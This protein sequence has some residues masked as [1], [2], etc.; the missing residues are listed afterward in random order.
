M[1]IEGANIAITGKAEDYLIERG[2]LVIPDFVA[3][4]GGLIGSYTEFIRKTHKET[5][6]VIKEKISNAMN[7]V[8]DG[9]VHNHSS[10]RE[11]ALSIAKEK[12]FRAMRLRGRA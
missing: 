3:N 12:V 4:S 1:I 5:Y 8:L 7:Q 10:P 2:V 11:I 6:E 9:L